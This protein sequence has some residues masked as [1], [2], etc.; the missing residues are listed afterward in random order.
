[1]DGI[2]DFLR[3]PA[4]EKLE[5]MRKSS[6]LEIGEKLELQTRMRK[7][8]LVRI[9]SEHTVDEQIFE[10]EILDRLPTE[11]TNLTA[12]QIQLEKY[13]LQTRL[14][15][16]KEK[17]EQEIRLREIRLTEIRQEPDRN[18]F[19]LAKQVRLV[20]EFVEANINEYFPHFEIIA[21]NMKWPRESW[22]MLLQT[23]LTGK[24]Q[25]AYTTL[26]AEDCTN[27]DTVKKIILQSFELVPEAYRQKFRN[28]RKS[29]NQS[30]MEF[31]KEKERLM[32]K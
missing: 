3:E 8:K 25:K 19:D 7:E 5:A 13:K 17:M 28:Q 12:E 31:V 15:L 21:T 9:I 1:M 18:G 22:A 29:E 2:E 30:F 6:L 24:A 11:S 20:P 32:N 16:E 4:L 27:Y 14:E 23:A 10:A 26:S